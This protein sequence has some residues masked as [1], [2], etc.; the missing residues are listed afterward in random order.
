ME[1]T[2]QIVEWLYNQPCFGCRNSCVDPYD[3]SLRCCKPSSEYATEPCP[4]E[5]CEDFE[6]E[7]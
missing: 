4:G 6:E 2:K 1:L 5:R 3:W 7:K